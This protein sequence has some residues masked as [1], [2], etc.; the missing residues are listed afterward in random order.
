MLKLE[1][2]VAPSPLSCNGVGNGAEVPY[3]AL[4][5]LARK[6]HIGRP[7]KAPPGTDRY[8][9]DDDMPQ[10]ADAATLRAEK[11]QTVLPVPSGMNAP[12]LQIRNLNTKQRRA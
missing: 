1:A 4:S 11:P 9:S 8:G 5:T 2:A 3:V 12:P 6:R 10:A 7:G